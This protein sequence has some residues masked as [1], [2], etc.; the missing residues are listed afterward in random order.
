GAAPARELEAAVAVLEREQEPDRRV[1]GLPADAR[2]GERLER[3]RRVV[4]IRPPARGPREP[5]AA[6]LV[7]KDEAPRRGRGAPHG[8]DAPVGGVER[9][10]DAPAPRGRES[11]DER[12]RRI[13]ERLLGEGG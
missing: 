12:R 10:A 8:E 11:C 3:R 9:L 1:H 2:N 5:A 6:R 4:R 13:A 7:R